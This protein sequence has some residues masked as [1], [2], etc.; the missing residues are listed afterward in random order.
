MESTLQVLGFHITSDIIVIVFIALAAYADAC[1]Y[2][3]SCTPI[4]F[5]VHRGSPNHSSSQCLEFVTQLG[6]KC[7][8]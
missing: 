1:R 4:S 6:K 8:L 2:I 3:L 7:F 5:R